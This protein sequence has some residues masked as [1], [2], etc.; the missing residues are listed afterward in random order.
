MR[1]LTDLT[2]TNA[3]NGLSSYGLYQYTWKGSVTGK[4]GA[5][6]YLELSLVGLHAPWTG[7]INPTTYSF[8][9]SRIQDKPVSLMYTQLNSDGSIVTNSAFRGWGY[10]SNG[11]VL[12]YTDGTA[13]ALSGISSTNFTF[14]HYTELGTVLFR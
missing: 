2:V 8:M 1:V 5:I 12:Y 3:I 11:L 13:L 9:R 7:S 14:I 10:E 6:V 4:G